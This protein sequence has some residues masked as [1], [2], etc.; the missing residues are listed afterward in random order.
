MGRF[1][2]REQVKAMTQQEYETAI[3]NELNAIGFK[4]KFHGEYHEYQPDESVF[5]GA[6]VFDVK[7]VNY[8]KQIGLL[9]NGKC[10]M[11]SVKEDL[12]ECIL[13][14]PQSG[15]VF[16]VCKS[17]YKRYARQEQ[18]KRSISCCMGII[19]IFALI[20]WGIVNLIS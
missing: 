6:I 16:H 13:Q 17:C 18:E 11:C 2:T 20:I 10:P 19:V 9:D 7:A 12:L 15:A 3:C 8:L 14:N 1:Y 5:G 4:D